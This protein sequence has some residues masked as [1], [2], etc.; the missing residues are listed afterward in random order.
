MYDVLAFLYMAF[1]GIVFGI[2]IG[3]ATDLVP[4]WIEGGF[5]EECTCEDFTEREQSR[6]SLQELVS[7]VIHSLPRQLRQPTPKF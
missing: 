3:R 5:I 2:I 6:Q 1:I 4:R 7:S